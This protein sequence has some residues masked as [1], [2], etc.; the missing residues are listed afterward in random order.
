M[1]A[2]KLIFEEFRVVTRRHL[3]FPSLHS[4]NSL[5]VKFDF[6]LVHLLYY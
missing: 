3:H 5:L 4:G 2:K 6:S 1:L